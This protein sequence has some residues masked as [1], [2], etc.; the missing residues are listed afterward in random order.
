MK[1][2]KILS[3]FLF[4][5][6]SGLQ[7]IAQRNDLMLTNSQAVSEDLYKDVKG[8]PFYFENWQKGKVYPIKSTEPVEEVVLNYNG[9]TQSFE[10]KKGNRFIALDEAWYQK[11][12]IPSTNKEEIVFETNLLPK[13]KN[14]FVKLV[15]Q[16]TDFYVVHDYFISLV[17]TEKERYAGNIEVQEF[18]KR[19]M[20]YLVQNGKTHMFKLKKKNVLAVLKDQK[21]AME[22]YLKKNRF[23]LNQEINL[24]K[25]LAHYE[26]L[27]RP[28][29]LTNTGERQ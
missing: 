22:S 20:Y 15:Y 23:K 17:T 8:S 29:E 26:E 5:L 10:V 1:T 21:K 3:L 7:I 6:G 14:Q 2:I 9:Y 19:P 13:R 25:V 11:V 27:T 24:V 12:V 28:V 4:I 16:G 18:V